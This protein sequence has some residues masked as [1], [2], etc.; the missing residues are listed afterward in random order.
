MG[1]SV[2]GVAAAVKV[3]SAIGGPVV[4]AIGL[5][6]LTGIAVY[7]ITG[8]SWEKS[9]ANKLVSGYEKQDAL[10]QLTKSVEKYWED[11][12]DS[13]IES[14]DQMKESYDQAIKELETKLN[15]PPEYF[16]QSAELIKQ[17]IN[18]VKKWIHS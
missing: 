17:T 6:I 8:R 14:G 11:T 16:Y 3:I 18:Q 1:I 12:K 5:S 2:G 7:R 13:M 4:L 10:S 9:F 15:Q